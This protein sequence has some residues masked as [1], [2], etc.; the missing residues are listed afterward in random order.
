[1]CKKLMLICMALVALF[2]FFQTASTELVGYWN[3]DE[4]SGEIAKDRSGNGNDGT[5]ENGTEWTG[6]KFGDAVP[7]V[8]LLQY[9][10]AQRP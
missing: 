8:H 4:G 3:F 9:P 7:D 10:R 2:G 5:L 1:M 6:G